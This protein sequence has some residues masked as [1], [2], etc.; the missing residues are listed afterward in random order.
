MPA[1][2]I[3]GTDS[4]R[5]LNLTRMFDAPRSLVFKAWAHPEH[6]MQWWGPR[7]FTVLSCEMDFR[8]GGAWSLSMRSPEGRVDRQ[9][10]IFR[11]IVE[12]ERIVFTYAFVDDRG[13]AGHE[14]VVSVS[15]EDL[16]AKTRLIL[17]QAIF[18]SVTLREEHV[19]GWSESFDNLDQLVA[20][21]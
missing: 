13:Q 8:I 6:V 3:D 14:M 21:L 1:K 20:K 9:R 2:S 16:G 10:G 18:E 15:F 7:G 19:A 4:E 5:V 17:H 11:D 12:P